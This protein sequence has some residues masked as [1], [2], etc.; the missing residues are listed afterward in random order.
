MEFS[1]KVR[2]NAAKEKIWQYYEDIQKWY[3]WEADLEDIT[4][5]GGFQTGSTGKMKLA[6]MPALDYTLTSVVE[7]KEFC[8]KT[9][10]PIGEL[11]FNHQIIEEG[12]GTYIQHSVRLDT[13]DVTTE[14]LGFLKQ[15]FADVPDSMMLLKREVEK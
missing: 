7:N 5:D 14:K 11:Y 10:T 8:D 3:T 9:V 13:E 4:L 1:F 15:V 6:G 2:V 12:L